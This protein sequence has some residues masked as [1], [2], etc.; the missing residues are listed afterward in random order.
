MGKDALNIYN[1]Q[2]LQCK[3]YGDFTGEAECAL[4]MAQIHV[5]AGKIEDSERAVNFL[6][7]AKM[8]AAAAGANADTAM[9]IY[10]NLG[11]GYEEQMKAA[12]QIL[13]MERVQ[14]NAASRSLP[15]DYDYYI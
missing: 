15:F 5:M 1:N 2:K 10:S 8:H 14:A 7:M 4:A 11:E 3:A 9:A 6:P 13:E 12:Q